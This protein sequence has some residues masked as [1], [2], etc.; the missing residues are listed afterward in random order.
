CEGL[1]GILGAVADRI[2]AVAAAAV[3]RRQDSE[4]VDT[5]AHLLTGLPAGSSRTLDPFTALAEAIVYDARQGMP[6]RFLDAG[7]ARPDRDWLARH[8]AAHGLTAAQVVARLTR[9]V[10]DA[11]RLGNSPVLAALLHD[12]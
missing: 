10:P 11:A 5:L 6:L 3:Q 4:R 8:A 9:H 2:G 7:P 1:D 12:A